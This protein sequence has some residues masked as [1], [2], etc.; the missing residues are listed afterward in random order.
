VPD[1]NRGPK[2][3]MIA[4]DTLVVVLIMGNFE[5]L[6]LESRGNTEPIPAVSKVSKEKEAVAFEKAK[7]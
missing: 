1:I 4:V 3:I 6:L 2:A 7:A 5:D